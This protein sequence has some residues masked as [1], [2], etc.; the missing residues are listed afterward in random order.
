MRN[1]RG[2]KEGARVGGGERRYIYGYCER[3]PA[4]RQKVRYS[5]SGDRNKMSRGLSGWVQKA[6]SII[7]DTAPGSTRRL[8]C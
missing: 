6:P 1:T 5:S 7:D 4:R 3:E 8:S 2:D